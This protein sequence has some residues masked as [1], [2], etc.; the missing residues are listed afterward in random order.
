MG[1][2]MQAFY[3]DCPREEKQEFKWWD[4]VRSRVPELAA[5]GFSALWL[6]PVHKA[7]NLGGP[8][9]GYDPYDYYD[10][11]EF[12]QKGRV[13]TWFGGKDGLLDLI[14]TAHEYGMTVLADMVIN[15]N[16]GADAEEL[17]PISGRSRWTLF[18]PR[19]GKFPRSWE[20]FHPNMYESWDE[21]TFGEMPDLSH[22][23]P[24]V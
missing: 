13:P 5:T 12:D 16:S 18:Q 17:N 23:N 21:G 22:R 19:S 3:W 14:G 6:P 8:S 9:M 2:M 15:H 11:G 4:L 20:C 7:A 1:V 10:L 24:Y